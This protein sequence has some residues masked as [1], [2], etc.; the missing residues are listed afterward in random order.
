MFICQSILGDFYGNA[1]F[2]KI[3]FPQATLFHAKFARIL[4]MMSPE[5]SIRYVQ[6]P[7]KRIPA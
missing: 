6:Q 2:F 5:E 3:F 1:W 4:S 7:E